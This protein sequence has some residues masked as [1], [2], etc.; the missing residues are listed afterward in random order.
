MAMDGRIGAEE[1]GA[2]AA[3]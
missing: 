2:V 1:G 3:S